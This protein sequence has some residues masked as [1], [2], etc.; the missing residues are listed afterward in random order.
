VWKCEEG[1]PHE[2]GKSY[3]NF[4]VERHVSISDF[5]NLL[6]ILFWHAEGNGK[7][8]KT[9]KQ[10]KKIKIKSYY[11]TKILSILFIIKIKL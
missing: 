4:V 7:I 2:H 3:S 1:Y 5:S 8:N 9:R 11:K 10:I 6:Q